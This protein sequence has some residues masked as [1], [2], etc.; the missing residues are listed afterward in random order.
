[1][2]QNIIEGFYKNVSYKIYGNID[3]NYDF[4]DEKNPIITLFLKHS[5]L[6]NMVYDKN[7]DNEH[8]MGDGVFTNRKNLSLT[9]SCRD[10][11]GLIVIGNNFCGLVHISWKNLYLGILDKMFE[12]FQKENINKNT[13]EFMILPNI[14][15]MEVQEN[16]IELW[17]D[18]DKYEYYFNDPNIF[19]EKDNKKYF[20]IEDF[21]IKY[22]NREYNIQKNKIISM[23]IST[24]ENKNFASFRRDGLESNLT[25]KF[26]IYMK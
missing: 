5:A 1:M 6:L 20:A 8:L 14:I 25:N 11:I 9:I 2:L 24:Y 13:L 26:I 10:C 23:F 21:I 15:K 16:F 17:R 19:I 4:P 18:Y 12:L 22:M 7:Y 3:N